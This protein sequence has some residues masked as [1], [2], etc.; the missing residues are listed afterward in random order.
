MLETWARE[1]LSVPRDQTETLEYLDQR[2]LL[3]FEDS[4]DDQD[5][6]DQLAS[7]AR[8]ESPGK[9]GRMESLDREEYQV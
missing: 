8:L 3:D 4:R 7:L 9:T 2:V 6:S 5:L 1:D